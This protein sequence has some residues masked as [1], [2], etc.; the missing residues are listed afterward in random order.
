MLCQNSPEKI[1]DMFINTKIKNSNNGSI[2]TKNIFFIWKKFLEEKNLPN[3]L[4]YGTLKNLLKNK[5][6]Y[7][8]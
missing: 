8:E 1:V 7:D 4:L 5:I 3:I 6:E 2:N